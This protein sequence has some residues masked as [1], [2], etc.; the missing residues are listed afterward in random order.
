MLEKIEREEAAIA[1]L[2]S[3]FKSIGRG[4][5]ECRRG[6]D[7]PDF[8]LRA[9]ASSIEMGVEH[10]SLIWPSE[11]IPWI[12]ALN[13]VLEQV[14]EAVADRV[15]GMFALDVQ[16]ADVSQ[17]ARDFDAMSGRKRQDLKNWLSGEL[18]A[19]GPDLRLGQALYLNGGIKG[20]LTRLTGEGPCDIR[21]SRMLS[22][23]SDLGYSLS[24]DLCTG[25]VTAS[26]IQQEH[27]LLEHLERILSSKVARLRTWQGAQKVLLMDDW[28][29]G[30]SNLVWLAKL[31][32]PRTELNQI[33]IYSVRDH[34][35][36]ELNELANG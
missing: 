13:C 25:Q 6:P 9:A 12:R 5:W 15:S 8:I 27:S 20:T 4:D 30:Q 35:I 10:T 7:P 11:E 14:A 17:L 28:S 21:V 26:R 19:R 24:V 2:V 29:A 1:R 22:R 34:R 23:G 36:F 32:K 18:L 3:H 33:Y 16:H 31:V